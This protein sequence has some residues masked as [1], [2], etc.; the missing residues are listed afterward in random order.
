[1]VLSAAKTRPFAL[2]RILSLAGPQH[3]IAHGI[4]NRKSDQDV[5]VT[6]LTMVST[7]GAPTPTATTREKSTSQIPIVSA[8]SQHPFPPAQHSPAT[9]EASHVTC[10]IR[11]HVLSGGRHIKEESR[12]SIACTRCRQN[13]TRCKNENNQTSCEACK[14][15]GVRNECNYTNASPAVS[16]KN[17]ASSHRKSTFKVIEVST[18]TMPR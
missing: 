4:I 1:M 8:H 15:R 2:L 16:N 6:A 14:E 11:G 12:A 7:S 18:P 17:Y 10:A 5:N 9:V 3:C 13:K